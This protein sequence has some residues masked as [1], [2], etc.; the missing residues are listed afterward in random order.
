MQDGVIDDIDDFV[1]QF[2]VVP[3]RDWLLD[4]GPICFGDDGQGFCLEDWLEHVCSYHLMN[5]P[6]RFARILMRAGYEPFFP[7]PTY[8]AEDGELWIQFYPNMFYYV[9]HLW[10]VDGW[11]GMFRGFKEELASS[12]VE[13]FVRVELYHRLASP[14]VETGKQRHWIVQVILEGLARSLAVTL[15]QPIHVIAVRKMLQFVGRETVYDRSWS[16]VLEIYN[17]QGLGGFFLGLAPRLLT[18]LLPFLIVVLFR[19]VRFG[20]PAT[21]RYV[22]YT[23]ESCSQ[24][25]EDVSLFGFHPPTWI[26]W[27]PFF[28]MS[29]VMAACGCSLEAT[30]LP[31][32]SQCQGL[33]ACFVDLI[34]RRRFLD[35]GSH[36]W[37]YCSPL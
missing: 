17:S 28:I 11:Y 18:E 24:M 14:A 37:R 29:T 10:D 22:C 25:V 7:T 27:N 23:M 30:R 34:R 20:F 15:S 36:F 2:M 4:D 26:I 31:N 3:M 35:G 13:M 6:L 9:Y 32:M 5:H 16:A 21:A 19:K 33:W 12:F 1:L 8:V